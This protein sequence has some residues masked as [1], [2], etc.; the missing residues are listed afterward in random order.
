MLCNPNLSS[1]AFYGN[2]YIF[3]PCFLHISSMI[4]THTHLDLFC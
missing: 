2:S 4:Q 3:P 1:P